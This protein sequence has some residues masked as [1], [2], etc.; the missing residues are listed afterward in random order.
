[1]AVDLRFDLESV[2]SEN[3]RVG[4]RQ[5]VADPHMHGGVVAEAGDHD[6]VGSAPRR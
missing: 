6:R 2:F 3:P 5:V 1:M 4:R